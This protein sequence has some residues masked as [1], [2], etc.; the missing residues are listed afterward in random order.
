MKRNSILLMMALFVCCACTG[1]KQDSSKPDENDSLEQTTDEAQPEIPDT[2][3]EVDAPETIS[4]TTETITINGVSITMIR[5][6]GGRMDMGAQTEDPAG[7]NYDAEADEE[8][9]PVHTETVGTFYL[10]ET[11]VTQEFWKA[12]MGEG[13]GII[14]KADF[15]PKHPVCYLRSS[16]CMAL[17]KR[18]NALTGLN[19]RYPTEAEWEFAA[20][21]GNKSK[22][23]KYSGSNNVDDVAWYNDNSSNATHPVKTKAPNELGLYDMS[24]NVSEWVDD[25]WYFFMDPTISEEAFD[26]RVHRGGAMIDGA[27]ECSVF[28]REGEVDGTAY[29]TVGFR[30]ALDPKE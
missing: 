23:Y 25:S 18:L 22:G 24:G 16:N 7:K 30:L 9:G 19:F 29:N 13:G 15:E 1:G 28:H 10:A 20:R 5:V 8:D 11:E 2:P 3:A 6:E 4:K 26:V 17:I 12:V 21:G 14:D 27:G